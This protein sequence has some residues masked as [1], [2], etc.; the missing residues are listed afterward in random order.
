MSANTRPP[1]MHA[2]M[3]LPDFRRYIRVALRMQDVNL[4][5]AVS[6]GNLCG[7]SWVFSQHSWFVYQGWRSCKCKNTQNITGVITAG[8]VPTVFS[9]SLLSSSLQPWLSILQ[10]LQWLLLSTVEHC[11]KIPSCSGHILFV[12]A[13]P[14]HR[15]YIKGDKDAIGPG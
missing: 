4:Q 8:T 15:S 10:T 13:M 14:S 7:P 12:P 3:F 1:D 9:L 11:R 2:C 6:R 5:P